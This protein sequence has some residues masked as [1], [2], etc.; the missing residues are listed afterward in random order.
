MIVMFV[1]ANASFNYHFGEGNVPC[2]WS[3]CFQEPKHV[4][5]PPILIQL[6]EKYQ[7]SLHQQRLE[8]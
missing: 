4:H 1:E 6:P 5:F 2:E 8:K 7:R 3:L